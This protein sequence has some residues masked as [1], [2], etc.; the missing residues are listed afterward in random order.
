MGVDISQYRATIGTFTG[1]Q[2]LPKR[3]GKNKHDTMSS[4]WIKILMIRCLIAICM[5]VHP[6][7]GPT[8][9]DQMNI[10][11]LNIRSLNADKRLGAC[12][13]Q[14]ADEYDI[15]TMSETW[16]DEDDIPE[17][18]AI[19]GYTGPY[20]L[21]RTL[22]RGGGVLAWVRDTI[23]VKVRPDLHQD[24]LETL[25]LELLI[26]KHK[27][28][29]AI[30]YRQQ[31]GQYSDNYWT[32]LQ[33]S[34]DLAK[35]TG[36]T[37]IILI[38]DFNADI[39]TN[40]P[41]GLAK[42]AFLAINHLS[43][44]INEPTRYHHNTGSVLDLIITNKQSL[45]KGAEVIAPVHLNDHCTIA[46]VIDLP[47]TRPKSYKRRM[48]SYK[49]A[50][51]DHFRTKLN[52]V[53]WE[54]CLAS[55]DPDLTTTEWTEK[56]L[57]VVNNEI[58]HK[59]VTVR[60]AEHK[61]YNG[62]L[63][64]LC[65]KQRH[66]HKLWTQ[67]QTPWAWERYRTSRNKYHQEVDRLRQ[68]YE[69]SLAKTLASETRT[70]PKK[71]WAVAKETMGNRKSSSIPSMM[72]NNEVYKTDEDKAKLFN[73]YFLEVQSLP[74]QPDNPIF[75]ERPEPE[76]T[77]EMVTIIPKDVED[78][79]KC[80]DPNKAYGP[81][82]ISPK[83]LKEGGPAIVNILTKLFNL[84]LAKGIF[85]SSWKMA[86]VCP[87]FKKAEE[88]FTKNYRPI[89]LL[90]TI[91]K[92]FE[93]VVFKHLFNFFRTNFT[94]SLWQSGF[95]PGHS[96]VTQ[97]IEIYDEFCKAVDNG[98][99]I[100]VVFLD[101]SKAFDR[102]WHAGLLDKLKG[103]GIRG[104]LLLWLKSYLT[105][106][107]QRVT[108]NGA[109]SPWGKILAGVPQ[110]S[111]LG[112]LL[113]LI[114]I[115][116]ITHVIRRCN[117]RLFA[118]DTC[119]FIEVDEPTEA[120]DILNQNLQQ[121][122]EWA[123]KWLVSFSPPKT[124]EL[125]I[126]NKAPRDHPPLVLNNERITRVK[127]HKHLGIYLSDNLGWKK[128]AEETAN[129][130]NRCLGILRPLKFILDR[131]S[132]ETLYKSFVRPILEYADIV[133]DAPDAHRHG[134]DILERVQ[135]EAARIVTGATA[136]CSTENLYKEAG[137]EKL[138]LRRRLHRSTMMFKIMTGLAPESLLQKI[139]NRVEARTRY[140]LRN[141]GDIQVPFTRL[142]S[143][144]QSFFPTAVRLWN[145]FTNALTNS[146]SVAAFKYNY[147]K[148]TP[149]PRTNPLVY[150]GE[151]RVAVSHSR[152]RI[153]CSGLN[154]DLC[155]ELHVLDSAA[156]TCPSGDDETA[157]HY[158]L[159][160]EKYR[161]ERHIM[162]TNLAQLEHLQPNC[163]LLL[164]GDPTKTLEHNTEIFKQVHQ[165]IK[166]S[167]RFAF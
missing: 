69:E 114:F 151:R 78:V 24:R 141:R 13:T 38:G 116:D 15:I 53:D 52:E 103:S 110:G 3:P 19:P 88:F 48:W 105:D 115:N 145:E 111:V 96:C 70:N 101:I 150:R 156:C 31:D 163:E 104:R 100:R 98:K 49:T 91:A 62:Y 134:L 127:H 142:V 14:L 65:R 108:I 109:R 60:P 166:T 148:A 35:A 23:V 75:E 1:L 99:E 20:R 137:W 85:P 143:Y 18:Y 102:V 36:M 77:I 135:T 43:Q 154:A 159:H 124:K 25:W 22:Q 147:L 81:D 126:S 93:K 123:D 27:L 94:I 144:T 139:P 120:A 149:R 32:K 167:K 26:P 106:R 72:S 21:D 133:W 44:H 80:L 41:A 97:L 140:R 130:A 56:F 33:Q 28:L 45:I 37:N 128:H 63:R 4:L 112:P 92:V 161:A 152:M 39:S 84:S 8:R 51:F 71:W 55:D 54:E 50:N 79:L 34:Y 42:D 95:L 160:C 113:F 74:N 119:L 118:D 40:R 153:G 157:D 82:G 10:C 30:C 64:K 87:I 132:L 67:H 73:D 29:L 125:L 57:E 61:W 136:R 5:D 11:H 6:H 76:N 2:G 12:V 58:P 117:I 9:L 83:M 107:Q 47:M 138:S 164:H 46:G 131:A 90:S 17:I 89:S 162:I 66:D 16:L 165:F 122:Q 68:E 158:L 86:N 146:P 121:I 129:K 59:D 7:P 155:R